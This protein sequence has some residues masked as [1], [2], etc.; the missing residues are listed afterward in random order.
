M[1]PEN[2]SPKPGGFDLRHGGIGSPH[3]PPFR[4]RCPRRNICQPVSGDPFG[5]HSGSRVSQPD[6]RWI[7]IHMAFVA[8]K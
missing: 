7:E 8:L 1:V 4:P 5:N 2:H 3:D 6:L